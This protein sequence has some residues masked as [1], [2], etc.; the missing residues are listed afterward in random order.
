MKGSALLVA[1]HLALALASAVHADGRKPGSLL[2]YPVHRS[3]AAFAELDSA[4]PSLYFTIVAVTNTNLQP[5]T[6]QNGLGGTTGAHFQYV[7]VT[8]D[9]DPAKS[10]LPLDCQIVN[11]REVLTPADTFSVLTTC[12]NAAD[13]QEGYLVVNAEDPNQFD[14]AWKF[15]Y[16]IGSEVVVTSLGGMYAIEAISFKAG[17]ALGA[18]AATDADADSEFDFDGIEYEGVAD[19]LYIDSFIALGGSSLALLNLTGGTAFEASVRFDI[20]ND[21]EKALSQ[22]IRFRCWFEEELADLSL[23]FTEP[24]LLGNTPNDPTELDIDCDNIGDLETGWARIRGLNASSSVESIP[25]A[26]LLGAVTAG[27]GGPG[28]IINGGHLLWE[29]VAVQTNGDFLKTG[30]DDPEHP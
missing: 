12:H 14:V 4:Y 19:D 22:T 24:F 27:P 21:A 30:T 18:G 17:V 29:S 23:F 16:L 2:V 10:L 25:N 7:N 15:D 8:P 11:R 5:A 1:G 13:F 6:P 20:W 26:A 3:G 9:P 28:V